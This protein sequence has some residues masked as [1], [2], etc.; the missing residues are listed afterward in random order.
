MK[1]TLIVL[2]I[3]VVVVIVGVVVWMSYNSPTP[4]PTAPTTSTPVETPS[5][6]QVG[7][8][9]LNTA[10]NPTLGEYIVSSNGMTLYMYTKDTS[11][12][13]NCTGVCAQNW[14][15]YTVSS[16]ATLN[17]AAGM[18]GTIST[19][20]R[21]DGGVQVTYKGSP[22]YYYVKDAKPGDVTGQG[23]GGV[24]FVVKP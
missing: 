16:A 10:T 12:V 14:P 6:A 5:G 11:G 3:I 22:L 17:G 9:T 13:S 18:T 21:A 20:T 1:N 7:V 24:W 4:V 2:L 8:L 23:V 19:L 15:P